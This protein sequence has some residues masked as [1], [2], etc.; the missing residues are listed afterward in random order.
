MGL[1][2]KSAP[3]HLQGNGITALEHF[4]IAT[5]TY[6]IWITDAPF[7]KIAKGGSWRCL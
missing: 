6:L 5:H 7:H 2:S 4:P 3:V 1:H